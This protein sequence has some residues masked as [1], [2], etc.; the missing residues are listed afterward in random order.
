MYG[1]I[2]IT[3]NI[4]T[5]KK[6][7]GQKKSTTFDT[8]YLGSGKLLARAIK[9][10]GKN[11]FECHILEPISG[12][13]TI[14]ENKES[15]DYAEFFYIEYY[16]CVKSEEYYNLKHGGSGGQ[17]R[18]LRWITNTITGEHKKVLNPNDYL[19]SGEWVQKGPDQSESTKKKR[20]L[21]NTGKKRSIQTCINISNSLKGKKYGP[22]SDSTKQALSIAGR[23]IKTKDNQDK[24]NLRKVRCIETGVIYPSLASASRDIGTCSANIVRNINGG[25]K[26]KGYSW[27]YVN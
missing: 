10:Y 6:Y 14:C 9:K 22:L 2:Y 15:L 3:T 21:S 18:G 25:S 8:T 13:N 24:K 20:A 12:V 23:R 4:V 16:N 5:N 7:I 26:T 17:M 19:S 27:E 11:N 1:Y